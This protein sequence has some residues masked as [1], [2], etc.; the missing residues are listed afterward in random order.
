VASFLKPEEGACSKIFVYVF[1]RSLNEILTFHR[2]LF[3]FHQLATLEATESW[4]L[5]VVVV[6]VA[7]DGAIVQLRGCG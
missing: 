7:I 6:S 3:L 2:D 4:A 5:T 1:F